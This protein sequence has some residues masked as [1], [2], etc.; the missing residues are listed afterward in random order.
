MVPAA[1]IAAMVFTLVLCFAIPIG[2]LLL[3]RRRY[4]RVGRAFACGMLAFFVSQVITRLPLMTL[5]V[6]GLPEPA[7]G[8]LLSVPVASFTAG[9]FEETGRLVVML[10]LLK[11][12]H[13]LADGLAFGLGHGGL[14]A[15]LL[16]G[17]T[18]VSNMVRAV[19]MNTGGWATIAYSLPA[20]NAAAIEKAMT[21]IPWSTFALAGVERVG[22]ITLHVLLSLVILTGIVHRRKA[23]AWVVAVLLHGLSNLGIL[24]AIQVGLPTAAVEFAFLALVAVLLWLAVRRLGPTLPATIGVPAPGVRD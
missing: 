19:L 6:P 8:F 15:M 17:V 21:Q 4:P 7:R 12:F 24:S 16:V 1:T 14:E 5:V 9:L 2:G 13:R 22:A 18:Y 3:L 10:L 20:E 11:A 23:L